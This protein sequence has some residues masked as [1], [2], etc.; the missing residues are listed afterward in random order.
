M[1]KQLRRYISHYHSAHFMPDERNAEIIFS[2]KPLPGAE[3]QIYKRIGD[4]TIS[5]KSCDYLTLPEC[6]IN[7]VSV[8]MSE[9][10]RAVYDQFQ[11]DMV[12][13]IKGKE[14]D[15][16][17]A[18]VL[19][20]YWYQHDAQRIKSRFDVREIKAPKDIEDWNAGR[21][22]VA[23]IHPVSAGQGLNLQSE[24][25]MLIWFG[26]TWS[27]ELYQ[28]T[29]VRLHRQEQKETVV[30]HHIIA[31]GTMDEDVMK[32]LRKKALN[33]IVGQMRTSFSRLFDG[34]KAYYATVLAGKEGMS[35][36]LSILN[37]TEDEY[38]AL[39]ESMNNCSGG[40]GET[41]AVMQDNLSS[42]VEQMGGALESLV[43]KLSD[44][45]I[46]FLTSLPSKA[47]QWGKDIIMGIVSAPAF[48]LWVMP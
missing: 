10:E 4:I 17:N 20:A 7:E 46:P 32:V 1:G 23:I 30:I 41:A 36:L 26:L 40:A 15:T 9:K 29:N 25:E 22:P 45:V 34:Q 27:F 28:Q 12:A 24:G 47:L 2:Y 6:V 39:S 48:P 13:K 16:V 11:E 42:K 19:I 44:Y 43:I 3:E 18:S 37:L 38:N 35:G 14:I 33:E 31:K 5:M 8:F 21:I